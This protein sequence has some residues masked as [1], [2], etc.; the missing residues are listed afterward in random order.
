[1]LHAEFVDDLLAFLARGTVPP[2]RL[3]IRV[4]ERTFVGMDPATFDPLVARGV[5]VIVDEVAR[6]MVSFDRLARGRISGLQLDRAWV[7][8]LRTD[9]VAHKVC[10]AGIAVAAALGLTPIATGVDDEAQ[11]DA[12]VELGCRYGTGDLYLPATEFLAGT[13][14]NAPEK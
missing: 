6:R 2:E 4:A 1:V 12:L 3:E 7:T 10:R 11:R 5:Q 8:A 13:L 14:R 9:P